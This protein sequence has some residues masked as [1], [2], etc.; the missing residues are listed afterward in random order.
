VP[1]LPSEL[2]V[3]YTYGGGTLAQETANWVNA[4]KAAQDAI[5]HPVLIADATPDDTLVALLCEGKIRSLLL[6]RG[7]IASTND[8][9]LFPF[10][11]NDAGR[12]N[13]NHVDLLSLETNLVQNSGQ[14]DPAFPGFK[15]LDIYNWM[16]LS[17]TS[18][19]T[20]E[21]QK[22]RELAGEI[23]RISAVSNN[24][25]P[26]KYPSPVDTIRQFIEG[27]TLN[28]NY[29]A[30]TTLTPADIQSASNGVS[31]A[32]AGVVQRPYG[33]F[34]LRVRADSFTGSCAI[35]ETLGF[36]PRSLVLPGGA[37][38]K[39]PDAFHLV[40]GSLVDVWAYT[41]LP[42]TCGAATLEVISLNVTAFPDVSSTDADGD[43]LADAW[44]D[45][46]QLDDPYGN[47]DGDGANNLKEFLDGTDP[48]DGLSVGGGTGRRSTPPW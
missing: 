16:S 6:N 45:L 15:L 35:L 20:A 9:T 2:Q 1:E 13:P 28:S 29:L 42:P 8:I 36:S 7:V 5:V 19:P 10:R 21:L 17:V 38:F 39:F 3:N 18:P 12:L 41:D 23:Y 32:I 25:A 22:L 4:A 40:P 11:P 46:F 24:V 14:P 37:P 34:V 26:A 44:E 48:L 31:E 30:V 43:L 33:S 47:P 27:G